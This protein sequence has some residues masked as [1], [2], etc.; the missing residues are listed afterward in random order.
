MI[1]GRFI[2]RFILIAIAVTALS[3]CAST[4][5]KKLILTSDLFI[6]SSKHVFV[7]TAKMSTINVARRSLGYNGDQIAAT[8][9]QS[10]MNASMQ[11]GYNPGAGLVGAL[12]GGA[13]VKSLAEQDAIDKKN[14]PIKMFLEDLANTDWQIL[15]TQT[16]EAKTVGWQPYYKDVNKEFEEYLL[17]EPN[18][19]LSS[20]YRAFELNVLVEYYGNSKKPVF[21]NYIFIQSPPI[22]SANETVTNLN[23]NDGELIQDALGKMFAQLK[24][25]VGNEIYK[26]DHQGMG[27]KHSAIKFKNALGE[28]YERGA[29]LSLKNGYITYRNLRGEI[30]HMQCD[31]II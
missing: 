6:P 4:S 21:R 18:L 1:N 5:K 30:K 24:D 16:P 22:L 28:F 31:E 13:I 19:Q 2:N 25:I 26:Q 14:E 11:A 7:N 17:I 20:N 27:M 29:I 9:Q 8:M 23:S 3:S 10:T 12:I 15:L